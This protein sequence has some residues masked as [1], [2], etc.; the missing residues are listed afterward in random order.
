MRGTGLSQRLLGLGLR[1]FSAAAEPAAAEAS[2]S[3][4]QTT[5]SALRARL[6]S[7]ARW[8]AGGGA[9]RQR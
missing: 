4:V 9:R 5:L 3:G 6:A 1:A 2:S 7:G 8:G